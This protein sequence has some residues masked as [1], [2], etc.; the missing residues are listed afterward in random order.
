VSSCRRVVVIVIVIVIVIV[1]V[2]VLVIVIV[3]VIVIDIVILIV[4]VIL[5]F[6]GLLEASWT[7]L[8]WFW[9]ASGAVREAS[10][11]RF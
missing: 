11:R 2:L 3:I 10:G 1:F 5:I 8:G 6:W 7:P 9:E 4:I